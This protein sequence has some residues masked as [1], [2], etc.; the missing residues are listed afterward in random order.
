MPRDYYEVLGVSK[1]ASADE[2]KKA[3]R[4]L[5][6]KYHPDKNPDNKE[7]EDKFKEAA[8][9]Y[10]V[11]STPEKKAQYD[12]FGHAGLGGAGGGGGRYSNMDDI[13]SQFG[14]IFGG[15][16]FESF[17][18]GG[19]QRNSRG[20]GQPGSNLRIKVKLTL[21]EILKGANKTIK[22][23]KHVSC[24]TCSG[25]GAKDS[26]SVS[27]CGTCRG[28]GYVR[29]VSN[30]FLGQMQTTVPCPTC[31]G[32]GQSITQKCA[33]C[34]GEGRVYDEETITLDIP[35][36]VAEGMQLSMSGK[37]NAGMNKGPAGDLLISIEEIP[38]E[39]FT[40]DGENIIHELYLNFADVAL[41]CKVDI[42]TL[43]GMVKLTIPEGTQSG[44]ILRLKDKGLPSLQSYGKG[45]MLVQIS[46]WTPKNL[47]SEE[48]RMLEK[49][50]DAQNFKP[51]PNRQE[52][53]F[54]ERM[55]EFFG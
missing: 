8:E 47:S 34:K 9:A 50:R 32:S 11:L 1:S 7:A 27:T 44:K 48:R 49:I 43:D 3:Y 12:R 46:V 28:A 41:G 18:G 22:V 20:G 17:F 26:N 36:G 14:D 33:P 4:Q 24:K 51:N 35:A 23:K 55:R 37:G 38:H 39:H 30:T 21:E 2:I 52:K 10:D 13:F 42:P 16:P 31:G 29:K 25:S 15:S 5:A 53:G 40:R 45:D 19:P 54:F 6:L